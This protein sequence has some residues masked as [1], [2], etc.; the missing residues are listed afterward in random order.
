MRM[1][2]AMAGEIF[3]LSQT[4][5]PACTSCASSGVA[6]LPVPIAQIGSYAITIFDQSSSERLSLMACSSV[7]QTSR[8]LPASLCSK[9]SP[10]QAITFKPLST[11]YFTLVPTHLSDSLR[12]WR[13]SE[14][15]SITQLTPK[16]RS[17]SALISPV[18]A[19]PF[20]VQ[21]FC[22]ASWYGAPKISFTI[23]MCKNGG[24]TTTSTS[25]VMLL[26]FKS[27]TSLLTESIVPV[28]FQLPPTI[29]FPVPIK[30]VFARELRPVDLALLAGEAS[31]RVLI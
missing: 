12:S 19:P 30:I 2:E 8:V 28:H 6:T 1:E 9:L 15:P 25:A 10:M 17:I 20:P 27:L 22:A 4:R 13:R 14:C 21:Q 3:L 24:A 26:E 31:E 29:N 11:A 5:I 7:V 23:P 16:S 18:N